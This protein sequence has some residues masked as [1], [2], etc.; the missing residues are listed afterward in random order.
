MK[1]A[2][3]DPSRSAIPCNLGEQPSESAFGSA[4]FREIGLVRMC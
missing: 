3:F 2:C 4:K 1:N